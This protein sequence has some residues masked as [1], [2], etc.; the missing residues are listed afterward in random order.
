MKQLPCNFPRG[1]AR[2]FLFF[3]ERALSCFS[4]FFFAF[5]LHREIG[6]DNSLQRYISIVVQFSFFFFLLYQHLFFFPFISTHRSVTRD[7]ASR[8]KFD[9]VSSDTEE[10]G[11]GKRLF[12]EERPSLLQGPRKRRTYYFAIATYYTERG[13]TARRIARGCI[14][15]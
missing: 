6:S 2:I 7:R 8:I 15:N 11:P 3:D 9:V 1:K 5:V 13:T 12:G 14:V 10:T 4:F